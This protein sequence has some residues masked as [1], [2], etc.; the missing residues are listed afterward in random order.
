MTICMCVRNQCQMKLRESACSQTQK[1]VVPEFMRSAGRALSSF[2]C[3]FTHTVY[4]EHASRSKLSHK[5]KDCWHAGEQVC[6]SRRLQTAA[7]VWMKTHLS[8]N[9]SS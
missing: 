9:V 7:A 1:Y 3:V 2:M 4:R 5:S 6:K 8:P